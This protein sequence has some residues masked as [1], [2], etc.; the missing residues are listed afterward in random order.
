MNL[1]GADGASSALFKL[2][3]PEE[4]VPFEIP[5]LAASGGDKEEMEREKSAAASCLPPTP[6]E[7][8]QALQR[9]VS[10]F[11][12]FFWETRRFF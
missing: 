9:K 3:D 5:S 8:S 11:F 1:D 12:L 6:V 7:Y 4:F 2:M 10:F